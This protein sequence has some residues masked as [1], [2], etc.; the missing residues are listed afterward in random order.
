MW[1]LRALVAGVVL[2]AAASAGGATLAAFSDTAVN[3][4]NSMTAKRI[5]PGVR[6]TTGWTVSDAADGSAA[7]ASDPTTTADGVYSSTSNWNNVYASN[8]YVTN[9]FLGTLP[10]GLG[11]TGAALQLNISANA[12]GNTLC[13][14]FDVIRTSTA[15]VLASHGTAA[16]PAGCVTGTTVTSVSTALPE[17]TTTDLANDVTIKLWARDTGKSA[18]RIDRAAITGSTA[19]D[20]FALYR[21]ATVDAA[22]TSPTTSIWGLGAADG[23]FFQANGNFPGTYSA[24]RYVD[25]T[26]P[27]GHVPTG[28]T[29]NGVD[30][31]IR[32]KSGSGG[33]ALCLYYQ[34]YSGATLLGTYGS[35]VSPWCSD[36]AGNWRSDVVALTDVDT[37][38][39]VNGLR[40]R[41]FGRVSGGG[42]GQFDLVQLRPDYHL[43]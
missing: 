4:G 31:S 9:E 19:Y 34:A 17:I 43:D 12:G 13:F 35:T 41:I 30:L 10:A 2:L 6:A 39:E 14:Y 25:V 7:N 1:R 26:F 42:S 8:R 24:T 23:T 20:S 5:F 38:A 33:K 21:A 40:L 3:S 18:L 28:S 15:A 11:V 32:F 27:A 36:T 16:T 22:D 29:I 37:V